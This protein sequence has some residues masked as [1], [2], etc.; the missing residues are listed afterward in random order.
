MENETVA[1]DTKAKEKKA[2]K[3]R[4]IGFL[5]FHT[6]T[7][8]RYFISVVLAIA[9]GLAY[10]RFLAPLGIPPIFSWVAVAVMGFFIVRKG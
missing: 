6:N 9:F 1:T 10:L 4:E 3:P 7:F 8:D 5:G 2:K